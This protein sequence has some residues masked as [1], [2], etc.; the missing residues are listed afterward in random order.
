L[1]AQAG[2]AK[3]AGYGLRERRRVTRRVQQAGL[4][5]VDDLHQSASGRADDWA[6]QK[7]GLY[8]GAPPGL[9][10]ARDEQQVAEMDERAG[11]VDG[12]HQVHPVRYPQAFRKFC[13]LLHERRIAVHAASENQVGR[14]LEVVQLGDCPDGL[15]LALQARE[16]GEYQ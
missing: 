16:V 7:H 8:S 5:V 9:P 12:A 10:M 3:Q 14:W 11:I 2:V 4:F 13:D 1:G 6:L 15:I